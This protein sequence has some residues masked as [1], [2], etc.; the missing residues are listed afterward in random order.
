MSNSFCERINFFSFLQSNRKTF[1]TVVVH[2][3]NNKYSSDEDVTD[4]SSYGYEDR[5]TKKMK[6][7]ELFEELFERNK[8]LH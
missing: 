5:P 4:E 8:A 1:K 3:L 6:F 2:R 7:E